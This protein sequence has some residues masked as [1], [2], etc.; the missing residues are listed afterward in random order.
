MPLIAL[1]GAY[2]AR[3][4]VRGFL[5]PMLAA[6][7]ARRIYVD[8]PGHGDSRPSGGVQVP[9]DVLDLLDLVLEEEG[10]PDGPF[11]VVGHSFG[12]H[13]ARALAARHPDRV[14]GMALICAAMPGEQHPAPAVVV[15]DDGVSA[16]LPPDQRDAY[17]G[18]FVVRTQDTLDRFRRA[19]VPATREVDDETLETAIAPGPHAHDPDAVS[20]DAP[21]LV[22]SARHDSWVGW[23][24]QE[25]LGD[26]YAH[27]TVVTA[28]DA[29]HALPHERPALL[30]ALLSE[31]LDEATG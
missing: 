14:A 10:A 20:V 26:L 22:V 21:V 1:H 4:E 30:A 31:W 5:E 12:A 15:R 24:R 27:A 28:A 8:L 3:A 29:G 11:L 16:S 9:D 25:H 7:A 17:E 23:E 6:R 19:V 13:F 18:Y 2:S